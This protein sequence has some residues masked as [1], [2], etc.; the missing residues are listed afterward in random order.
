MAYILKY[1]INIGY[2]YAQKRCFTHSLVFVKLISFTCMGTPGG[3]GQG[4]KFG[5]GY[6][7]PARK[8]KK[9]R[10]YY[11]LAVHRVTDYSKFSKKAKKGLISMKDC[12]RLY[13]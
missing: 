12:R 4:A 5:P 11:S 9:E 2:I 1:A 8:T 13:I 10:E 3:M 7:S 6:P